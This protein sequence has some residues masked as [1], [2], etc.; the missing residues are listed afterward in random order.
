M[1]NVILAGPTLFAPLIQNAT[2]IA[3]SKGCY[4]GGPQNYTIL[5]I[6]TDG[7]INE[8]LV[9]N[10]VIT[11]FNL[12]DVLAIDMLKL[13][14]KQENWPFLRPFLILINRDHESLNDIIID[15]VITQKLRELVNEQSVTKT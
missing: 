5:L 7:V 12:F 15:S 13:K 6:I 1:P 3:A 10:H 4:Q 8:H 14:I 11:L 2:H 9:L